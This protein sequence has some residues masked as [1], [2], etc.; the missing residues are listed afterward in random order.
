LELPEQV[1]DKTAPYVVNLHVKDFAFKRNQ[2]WVGFYYS[3]A[4]LGDGLLNFDYMYN[5]VRKYRNDEFN[6]IVELWVNFEGTIEE[7][8]QIEKNWIKQSMDYLR[9][10]IK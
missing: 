7:T 1:I 4:P 10:K 6:T 3:G 8:I 2:G 9:R 5:N